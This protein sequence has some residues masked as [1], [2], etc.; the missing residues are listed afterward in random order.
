MMNVPFSTW[1][2]QPAS[3]T[4]PEKNASGKPRPGRPK[5]V[6][7]R[8]TGLLMLSLALLSVSSLPA[9]LFMTSALATELA[10]IETQTEAPE[11]TTLP[12]VMVHGQREPLTDAS[13]TIDK[14]IIDGFPCNNGNINE[15]LSFL[16]DIQYSETANLSTQGGEI[17][18]SA[19]SI[20]GG[21]S[22]ENNF[23]IDGLGNNSLLDPDA[24]NPVS[25]EDVPGHAQQIFL[26]A[27]LVDQITL[28][29]SN[30]PASYGNFKGG[31]VQAAT[32]E[33]GHEFGGSL[34]Y[35]TTRDAWTKFHIAPSAKTGFEDSE[36]H[37]QQPKFKKHHAGFDIH[38]PVSSHLRLLAAYRLQLA[39]IP[40]QHLGETRNQSRRNETFLIK[41]TS[42]LTRSSELTLSWIYSPYEARYFKKY[43]RDS[44][45][46]IHGGAYVA[47]AE[48]RTVLPFADLHLQAGY[49]EGENSREGPANMVL[50]Q[51]TDGSWEQEGFPGDIEKTQQS[52]QFKP[53]LEFHRFF[54][55]PVSHEINT[56]FDFQY[57]RGTSRRDGTSYLDYYYLDGSAKRKVYEKHRAQATLRQ[58]DFYIEDILHYSRLEVRPGLR[59]SYDDFMRNLNFAPRLAAAFDVFGNGRTVLVGGVNRYYASTLLTYKLR[60]EIPSSY[61]E[62]RTSDGSWNFWKNYT[63][64]TNFASLKTPYADEYV[65][66]LEQQVFGGKAM[67]KYVQ[68]QGKDEFGQSFSDRQP[69]GFWYYS[70]NNNGRSHHESYRLSWEGQ[71]RNHYVSISGTYQKTRSSNESYDDLFDDDD[72]DETVWYNGHTIYK[73]QL[74]RKNYNRPWLASL[75]YAGRLPYGVT[76]SNLLKYRSGYQ[77]L[78]NTYHKHEE[79]GIPIYEKVKRG[80]TITIDCKIDWRTPSWRGQ[81]FV[82]SLEILNLL[83]KKSAT[84][85]SEDSYEMG[86]QFWL[87]AKYAF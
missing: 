22:F 35:R 28:Y 75:L 36:D 14:T 17:V 7:N 29:D 4:P 30:V 54:T 8:R 49:T 64:A 71:W 82:L 25:H 78:E 51:R 61:W 69:D 62:Q 34:F 10:A 12:P 55:G 19:V 26:D 56:G 1:L 20:S 21:K 76:F 59:L 81:H 24:N 83:N 39:T 33:P 18:P 50:T 40:L 23:M 84:G 16:P 68:R 9:G 65:I 63:T 42:E 85:E 70:L 72:L 3:S 58:F 27:S 11:A 57:I 60:S 80:G 43:F 86:R 41:L 67:F 44:D 13:T 73:S 45:F 15:I 66:G 53:D 5:S 52:F 48:Y 37:N 79:L 77:A 87:G 31:V 74:P 2:S 47:N 46:T 38:L 6:F 32:I